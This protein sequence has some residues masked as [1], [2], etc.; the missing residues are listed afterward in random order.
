METANE[1]AHTLVRDGVYESL[2]TEEYATFLMASDGRAASVAQ[3]GEEFFASRSHGPRP[4]VLRGSYRE[5]LEHL[6]IG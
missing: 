1:L 2:F 3:N 4:R 5:A 6:S